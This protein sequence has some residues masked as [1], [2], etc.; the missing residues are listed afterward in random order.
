MK[1]IIRFISIC[2]VLNGC[3]DF[4]DVNENP[5]EIN[6]LNLDILLSSTQLFIGQNIG[7]FYNNVGGFWAQY[8]AQSNTSSTYKHL[9]QYELSYNDYTNNGNSNRAWD[10][11]YSQ[12][13]NELNTGIKQSITK[14]Q[15]DYLLIN[16]VLQ[17]YIYQLLVDY[18]NEIPYSE[19]A[20]G[21][22]PYYIFHPKYDN[23]K[24]IYFDLLKKLDYVIEKYNS[25]KYYSPIIS[26]LIFDGNMDRWIDFANTLKLKL[27]IRI[28]NIY[29]EIAKQS[30]EHM[31]T[32]N[33]SF[34]FTDAKIEYNHDTNS[35]YK[36]M[37]TNPLYY[38]DRVEI[39]SWSSLRISSTLFLYYENNNDPRL[40]RIIDP[41]RDRDANKSLSMPQGGNNINNENIAEYSEVF[42]IKANDPVYLISEVESYL[43]QAEAIARG[44]GTGDDK[45][46][47]DLAISTDFKRKG[48][49]GQE[50]D[51][52]ASGG[53]YSYS[54]ADLLEE[55]LKKIAMAKWAAFAGTQGAE[56]FFELNRTG[57]PEISP[58]PSWLNNDY[59]PEYVGGKLTYSLAGKTNGLFPKRLTYPESEELYNKNFPGQTKVSDKVWWDVR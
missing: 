5:N 39:C 1:K 56:A 19:A 58:V 4:L 46:L 38:W 47:Y 51:L 49:A 37:F 32:N 23:G 33:T 36:E 25:K 11:I 44:W 35:Y 48:L 3:S 45:E 53:V 26:D 57:Y 8:W 55:K 24:Y 29:P 2:F 50:Q 21:G 34:L 59:N 42:Y 52:I 54:S 40:K 28:S 43:L 41:I 10:N 22:S 14:E 20:K 13:I 9:E 18:Y 12:S 31:Y 7:S 17:S 6:E 16:T 15:W 30:I 27:L